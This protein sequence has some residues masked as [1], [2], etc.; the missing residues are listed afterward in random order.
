MK[1]E[2]K[3]RALLFQYIDIKRQVVVLHKLLK[4]TYAIDNMCCRTRHRYDRS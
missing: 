4:Q 3:K 1:T 2:N